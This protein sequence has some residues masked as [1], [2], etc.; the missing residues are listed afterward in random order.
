MRSMDERH[1]AR[2]DRQKDRQTALRTKKGDGPQVLD[3]A[4]GE[5][6][7]AGEALQRVVAPIAR[8]RVKLAWGLP[9]PVNPDLPS[10]PI[11]P[12]CP[13]THRMI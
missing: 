2:V 13:C 4:G 9:V 6:A 5:V 3:E 12:Y 1:L 11:L 7:D 10:N 8:V